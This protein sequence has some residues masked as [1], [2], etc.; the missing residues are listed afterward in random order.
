MELGI[1]DSMPFDQYLKMENGT[2]F[3]RNTEFFMMG[4]APFSL[5]GDLD[6]IFPKYSA[7]RLVKMPCSPEFLRSWH[8]HFDNYGNYMPGFCG[9]ITLGDSRWLD[10]LLISGIELDELPV[11][12]FLIENDMDGLVRFAGEYG[13]EVSEVGY[14]S[15]CHLCADL[16]KFLVEKDHFRELEPKAFYS[17]LL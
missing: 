10:E 7:K 16:R 3:A 9:G 5:T 4:R 6:R 2:D 14:Y 13:Y 8:N 11:L 15:K 17:N 1:R 12:K